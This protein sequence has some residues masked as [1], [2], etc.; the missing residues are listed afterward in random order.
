MRAAGQALA[1]GIHGKTLLVIDASVT[2]VNGN[3]IIADVSG[4]HVCVGFGDI[5]TVF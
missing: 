5:R 4:E 3:I 2:P 1:V